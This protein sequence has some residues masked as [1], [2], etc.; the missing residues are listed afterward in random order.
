MK[1]ILLPKPISIFFLKELLTISLKSIKVL[2]Q[3][4]ITASGDTRTHTYLYIYTFERGP[5][6]FFVS[7]FY[8]PNRGHTHQKYI[9]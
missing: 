5:S 7:S 1:N 8:T 9:W 2:P 4:A 3:F 6:L